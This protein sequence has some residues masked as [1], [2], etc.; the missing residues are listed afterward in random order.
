MNFIGA[1]LIHE[2]AKVY[3]TIIVLRLLFTFPGHRCFIKKCIIPPHPIFGIVHT[4]P[5]NLSCLLDALKSCLPISIPTNFVVHFLLLTYLYPIIIRL[6]HYMPKPL[7][8]VTPY[9]FTHWYTNNNNTTLMEFPETI[10][11][12]ILATVFNAQSKFQVSLIVLHSTCQNP[13]GAIYML[14]MKQL[15]HG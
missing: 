11:H 2:Q 6:S 12:C 15:E 14:V 1:Y 10:F 8:P 4:Y 3:I 13:L 9:H 7:E 5:Q